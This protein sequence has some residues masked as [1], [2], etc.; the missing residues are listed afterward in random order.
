[1]G[2]QRGSRSASGAEV[3]ASALWRCQSGRRAAVE[4]AFGQVANSA[5]SAL[6]QSPRMFLHR[7]AKTG[8]V[9]PA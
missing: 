3:G 9:K 5:V 6:C 8:R 2:L 4:E 7:S 1:M